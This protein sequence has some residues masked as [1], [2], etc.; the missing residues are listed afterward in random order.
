[1]GIVIVAVASLCSRSSGSVWGPLSA[2]IICEELRVHRF[3]GG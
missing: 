1:M 2:P 3:E